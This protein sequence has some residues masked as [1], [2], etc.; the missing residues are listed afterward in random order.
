MRTRCCNY[1]INDDRPVVMWN[2]GN[3]VVQCHNCGHVYVPER[4]GFFESWTRPQ[5]IFTAVLVLIPC[6]LA[7]WAASKL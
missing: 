3:R 7:L 2:P 1:E 4:R 5:L 6:V